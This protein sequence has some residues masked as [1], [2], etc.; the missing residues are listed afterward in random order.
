LQY[1][2]ILMMQQQNTLQLQQAQ[3]QV[4]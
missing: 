3:A 4:L 1:Q 2:Q